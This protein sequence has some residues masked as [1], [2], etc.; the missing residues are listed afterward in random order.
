MIAAI[1]LRWVLTALYTLP[2]LYGLRSV[3][4]RDGTVANRMGHGLHVVTGRS[5]PN[6]RIVGGRCSSPCRTC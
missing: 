3:V 1:G 4:A 5:A 6:P 2:V